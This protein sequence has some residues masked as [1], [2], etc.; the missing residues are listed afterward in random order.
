VAGEAADGPR[1]VNG[2]AHAPLAGPTLVSA[3]VA[4]W[5]GHGGA[6]HRRLGIRLCPFP[7]CQ[8]AGAGPRNRWFCRD[9]A[10]NVPVREQKRILAERAKAAG[11]ETAVFDR[12][13]YQYHGRVKAL[14]D[15][16][17]EA[18]LRF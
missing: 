18:G 10:R 13:G 8:N 15:G 12:G 14:A 4:R 1:Q 2:S 3:A 6:A 7:G 16:A 5:R 17:R 11:I 9:H